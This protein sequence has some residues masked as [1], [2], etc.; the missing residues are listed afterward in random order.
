MD[1]RPLAVERGEGRLGKYNSEDI[2]AWME[3]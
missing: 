2:V 3:G 1:T